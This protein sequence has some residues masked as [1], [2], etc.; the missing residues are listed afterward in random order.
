MV[1]DPNLGRD[2]PT[3]PHHRVTLPERCSLVFDVL[4]EVA[5]SLH[6]AFS[7]PNMPTPAMTAVFP[8]WYEVGTVMRINDPTT[9]WISIGEASCGHILST[10][11]EVW[12][13]RLL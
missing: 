11:S 3:P 4:R 5:S 8:Y 7:R 6:N 9:M 13:R 10:A 1:M 12:A 2:L